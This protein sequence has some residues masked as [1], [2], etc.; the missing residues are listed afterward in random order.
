MWFLAWRNCSRRKEQSLLTVGISALTVFT[1]VLIVLVFSIVHSSLELSAQRM[2]ADL[3]VLPNKVEADAFQTVFTAEPSNYYMRKNIVKNL[4]GIAGIEQMTTQ[5]FTQTLN[6][7][8]CSTGVEMRL[9]GYDPQSDF[10]LAPWFNTRKKSSLAD[11]EML[12]GA[13]VDAWLGGRTRLLGESMKVVGRLEASGSGMDKTTFVNITTARRMAANSPYLRQLWKNSPPDE[14]IS[15]VLIKS[16]S[17]HP[18]SEIAKTINNLDLP[19]RAYATGNLV[20]NMRQQIEAVQELVMGVWLAL[21]LV[22]ALALIGRFTALARERKKEIGLLRAIGTPKSGIFCLLILES[23][24]LA[25]AG[26]L[27]GGIA[28][29]LTAPL[30]MRALERSLQ[31]PV[32]QYSLLNVIISAL[33]GLMLA[34]ILGLAASCYPAWRSADM[35]PQETLAGGELD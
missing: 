16:D 25:G 5:F 29:V 7:S 20:S 19:V 23:G 2:G 33:E 3:I 8:C 26:G 32:I 6:E 14:L 4:E 1:F 9:V 18:A 31:L 30:L 11:D 35:S 21:L 17:K 24:I 22:A 27:L 10:I 15:S 13:R 12:I 34:L 28:G